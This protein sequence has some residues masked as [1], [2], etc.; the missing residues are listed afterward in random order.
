[1]NRCHPSSLCQQFGLLVT[2]ALLVLALPAEATSYAGTWRY[3]DRG[4]WIELHSDGRAYQCRIDK[5]EATTYTSSGKVA[6]S[7]VKWDAI[8]GENEFEV[9]GDSLFVITDGRRLE[10]NRTSRRMDAIC[11]SPLAPS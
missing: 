5:D 11:K 9:R 3:K 10:F 2:S 7:R 4:V 1:M 8:W 6:G